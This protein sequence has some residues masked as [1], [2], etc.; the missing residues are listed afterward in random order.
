MNRPELQESWYFF[1]IFLPVLLDVSWVLHWLLASYESVWTQAA[2]CV[3]G[4]KA[5]PSMMVRV[6][7]GTV[8]SRPAVLKVFLFYPGYCSLALATS[9]HLINDNIIKQLLET[10]LSIYWLFDNGMSPFSNG[11]KVK[12]MP[13]GP[14]LVMYVGDKPGKPSHSNAPSS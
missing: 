13:A 3:Q 14:L 2:K 9:L 1:R 5:K 8:Q 6:N 12:F 7:I 10:K 11:I 4:S